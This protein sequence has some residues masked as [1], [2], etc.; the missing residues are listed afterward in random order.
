MDRVDVGAGDAAV[1]GVPASVTV[2]I[3]L[4]PRPARAAER[5]DIAGLDAVGSQRFRPATRH[6]R[7][8]GSARARPWP[9]SAARRRSSDRGRRAPRSSGRSARPAGPSS[10]GRRGWKP[11]ADLEVRLP[12]GCEVRLAR[13]QSQRTH[14]Q[15]HIV[16]P[17]HIVDG[18]DGDDAP[19]RPELG[20][21]VCGRRPA[22]RQP[23]SGSAMNAMH[24]DPEAGVRRSSSD[25]GWLQQPPPDDEAHH[26]EQHAEPQ[27]REPHEQRRRRRRGRRDADQPWR[28]HD[29]HPLDA[30]EPGRGGDEGADDDA[31][32]EDEDGLQHGL[33][34][35]PDAEAAA[36]YARTPAPRAASYRCRWRR[37]AAVL[38]GWSRV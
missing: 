23:H 36:R 12:G 35:R 2:R 11:V 7:T 38:R 13:V 10:G 30:A 32:A 27:R 37:L 16:R 3:S 24:D 1:D 19:R 14:R 21:D 25:S 20:N 8:A 33:H 15:R 9:R 6:G 22:A 4:A 18:G 31:D 29:Q 5:D 34:A 28:E 26:A 17:I